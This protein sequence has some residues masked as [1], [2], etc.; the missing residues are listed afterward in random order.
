M[1]KEKKAR[2]LVDRFQYNGEMIYDIRMSFE[3]AKE[4]ALI[5]IHMIIKSHLMS[6]TCEDTVVEFWKEVKIEIERYKLAIN[7]AI[8]NV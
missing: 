7:L 8:S 3:Q 1:K 5:C 6:I 4:S 2:E